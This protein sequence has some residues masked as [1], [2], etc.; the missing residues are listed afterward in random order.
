M[1]EVAIVSQAKISS[2]SLQYLQERAGCVDFSVESLI[3]Q[4]KGVVEECEVDDIILL[5]GS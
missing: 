3:W 1:K 2:R 4:V 5:N